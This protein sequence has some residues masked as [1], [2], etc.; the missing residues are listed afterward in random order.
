MLLFL[1]NWHMTFKELTRQ[2]VSEE[3]FINLEK[4]VNLIEEK[5]KVMNLT[6]FSGDRLWQEGIYESIFV[7]IEG[8][9]KAE[10]K[11]ILDIGAG[12]GFPSVPYLIAFP[13]NKLTIYEPQRKRTLFL[14]EVKNELNLN[15]DIQNIR[16]EDSKDVEKFDL[17]TA[18]AVASFKI[19][20]EISH[21]PAKINAQFA[22]M[23]GP[24]AQEELNE[25]KWICNKLSINAQI[26]AIETRG[27]EN[28]IITY[29]K[30]NKTPE[31]FPRE[32]KLIKG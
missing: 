5:N 22:F 12:A 31:G 9:G 29:K 30:E 10:S 27:R 28:N 2:L 14:E 6:G 21:R 7:L 32:W 25:S 1:Y 17:I 19:L 3:S 20:A 26:R 4:Y 24:K 18:R 15:I 13:N 8:F 16:A 23:K 11:E